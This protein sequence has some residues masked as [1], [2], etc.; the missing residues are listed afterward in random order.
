MGK[1][2]GK[3]GRSGRPRSVIRA[4]ISVLMDKHGIEVLKEIPTAPR[5]TTVTSNDCGH[6]QKVKP[7][8]SDAYRLRAVDI[9]D[10]GSATSKGARE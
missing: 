5:E 7:P 1:S 8:T 9:A 2:G 4:K 10:T 6:E 3:K